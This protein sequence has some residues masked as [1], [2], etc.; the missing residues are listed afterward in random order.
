MPL[1]GAK[2]EEVRSK[3]RG[4][5]FAKREEM[6]KKAAASGDAASFPFGANANGQQAGAPPPAQQSPPAA[7][8]APPRF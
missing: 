4:L 2:L 3:L 8:K 1:E 5:I 6:A 7:A